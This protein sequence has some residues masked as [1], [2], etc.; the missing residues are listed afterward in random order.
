MERDVS[1]LARQPRIVRRKGST[2]LLLTGQEE[3]NQ[4]SDETKNRDEHDADNAV[5]LTELL[6]TNTVN[7]RPD[8]ETHDGNKNDAD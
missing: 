3:I 5:I 8:P 1:L 6:I 7:E 2:A 4:A